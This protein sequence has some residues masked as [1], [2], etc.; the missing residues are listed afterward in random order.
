MRI[1]TIAFMVG[2]MLACVGITMLAPLV[3]SLWYN[4]GATNGIALSLCITFFSGL[5]IA[6]L[7]RPRGEMSLNHREGL[8]IVGTCWM[9]AVLAGSLPFYLSGLLPF[10][11]SIFEAA[12]G[13]TATGATILQ[14]VEGT[15]HALLLWRSLSHWLGGMGIIVLSIAIMPFLG[16]GGMQ[17]YRAEAP[18]P[19]PDKLTPRMR[20][21]ATLLWKVYVALTVCLFML[22]LFCGMEPFDAL[23]HAFSTAATGGFSTRDASL[24]AYPNPFIQWI[25]VLFMF[26][27]STNF[28]LHYR[29]LHSG[30]GVYGRD[31]EWKAYIYTLFA[32]SM[33]IALCLA[34]RYPSVEETLRVAVFHVVSIS[35]ST[36]YITSNYEEWPQLAQAVLVFFM[37]AGGCA[38]STSGGIKFMRLY[39]LV[40]VIWQELFRLAHPHSITH[41]KM[42]DRPIPKEV[43]SGVISFFV[44]YMLLLGIGTLLL[45]AFNI[46]LL[47]AFGATLS[48]LSNIGPGLGS[49]GPIENYAHF[50]P[51]VHVLLAMFMLLGRLEI[52]AILVFFLPEFWRK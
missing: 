17:L 8:F 6:V 20:D 18:S 22:L 49:V 45:S 28:A 15:P 5:A 14:T 39:I 25:V 10:S 12:S 30:F 7:F 43:V 26:I 48:C 13:F 50:P 11:E 40:R 29:F 19:N 9:S 44:L 46:D 23:N 3:A 35:T 51:A 2:A 33:V 38:G 34:G 24:G 1:Y 31:A 52:Y 37:F 16:V 42:N 36:G 32:G 27:S 41:L 21:T 4:D 47:S